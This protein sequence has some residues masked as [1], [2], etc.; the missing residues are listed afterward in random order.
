MLGYATADINP[1]SSG[2]VVLAEEI[3][4]DFLE[5]AQGETFQV[6][7]P[8]LTI[9]QDSLVLLQWV[10]RKRS[11]VVQSDLRWLITWTN[12]A[13]RIRGVA[14]EAIDPGDSG[15]IG[16]LIPIDGVF[17]G[18]EIEAYLPTEYVAVDANKVVWCELTFGEVV[19]YRWEIYSADCEPPEEPV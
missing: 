4:G 10:G 3:V 18:S 1:R 8:N 17:G 14:T 7:N 19:G 12:S 11:V 2:T 5:S 15:T 6:Y 13:R 16:T 9:W